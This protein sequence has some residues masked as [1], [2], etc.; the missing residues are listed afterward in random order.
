MLEEQFHLPKN[1]AEPLPIG[2]WFYELIW[3]P[4]QCYYHLQHNGTD[5]ILYLRWRWENPWQAHV[6]KNA[7]SL[8]GMHNENVIWSENVF[9]LNH[10]QF[11]EDEIELTKEKIIDLFNKFNGDF[12]ARICPKRNT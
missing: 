6:V 5:Y 2:E 12:P 1:E 8:D 10:V 9:E 4:S 7:E 11:I 3:C